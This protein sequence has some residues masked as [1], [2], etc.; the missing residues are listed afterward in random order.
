MP[1]I[2]RI[3]LVIV[4]LTALPFLLELLRTALISHFGCDVGE[5]NLSDCAFD[6]GIVVPLVGIALLQMLGLLVLPLGYFAVL[7][8]GGYWLA[9]R[10]L[11]RPWWPAVALAE[12]VLVGLGIWVVYWA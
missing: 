1:R 11:S 6:T 7:A 12:A 3:A 10:R 9:T 4:I 5:G 8:L 2:M